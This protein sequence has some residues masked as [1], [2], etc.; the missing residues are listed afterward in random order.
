MPTSSAAI[1]NLGAGRVRTIR[2]VRLT[3]LKKTLR[4]VCDLSVIDV[5]IYKGN[6]AQIAV[7]EETKRKNGR[8]SFKHLWYISRKLSQRLRE[9][10]SKT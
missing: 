4:V 6:P 10:D 2:F 8:Q 9:L 1:Q 3:S 7:G 5:R